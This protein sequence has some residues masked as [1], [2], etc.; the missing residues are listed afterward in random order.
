MEEPKADEPG[1][2]LEA[3]V[4]RRLQGYAHILKYYD[5]DTHENSRYLVMQLAGLSLTDLRHKCP[6]NY[7]TTST[8]VRIALQSLV[9]R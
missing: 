5:E 1:L 8:S 9:S 2:H 4:L 7:F 3:S 6:G